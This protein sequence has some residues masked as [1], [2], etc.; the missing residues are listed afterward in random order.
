MPLAALA[1]LA[2]GVLLSSAAAAPPVAGLAPYQ[3]PVDAPVIKEFAHSDAWRT[4][5]LR[6]ISQ[7]PPES[8]LRVLDHQGAW[9]TPFNHAGM[10]GP[11]D[12]RQLHGG[13]PAS[14]SAKR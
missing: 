10:P 14:P 8:V 12:L 2:C 1:A 6:G 3:R 4:E 11:Y 5:A 9:Y 13:K 7:P